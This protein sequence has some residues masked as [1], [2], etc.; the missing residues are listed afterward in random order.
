MNFNPNNRSDRING[1]NSYKNSVN[2]IDSLVSKI[3]KK[4]KHEELFEN[5]IVVL[6]ADH[7]SEKYDMGIGVMLLLLPTNKLKFHFG[8]IILN[9]VQKKLKNSQIIMIL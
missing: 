9:L 4:L 8:Y 1:L 6:T 2:Y 5:S 3:F 7:G